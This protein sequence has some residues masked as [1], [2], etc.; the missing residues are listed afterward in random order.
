MVVL[1]VLGGLGIALFNRPAKSDEALEVNKKSTLQTRQL[2]SQTVLYS[3]YRGPYEQMGAAIGSLYALAGQKG[4]IPRGPLSCAFLNNPQ[5]V[6]PQHYLTEIRIPVDNAALK[7]SGSLGPFTDIKTLPE[8]EVAVAT[9][10]A[11]LTDPA[12]IY[13]QLYAKIFKN[14]YI[15]TDS[16]MELYL[17]HSM[18]ADYA[19]MKTEILIPIAKLPT[20]IEE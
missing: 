10:P 16:A 8:M 7:H 12:P 5:F 19:Q 13:N 3:I 6:S 11:G 15:P 2:K 9:R 4:I 14:G 1:V 18:T 20:I 17:D